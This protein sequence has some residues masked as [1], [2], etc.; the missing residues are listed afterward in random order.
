MDLAS[1]AVVDVVRNFN[2]FYMKQIGLLREGLLDTPFSLTQARIIYELGQQPGISAKQLGQRLGLDAGY[3]SRQVAK[4][5]ESGLVSR[6]TSGQ[7]GRV[8]QLSLTRKG[9]AAFTTLNQRSTSEVAEQLE[10]LTPLDQKKLAECMQSI[11]ALLERR[12]AGPSVTIRAPLAGDMGWVVERQGKVYAQEYNWDWTYEALVAE[13]VAK[14]IRD[15]DPVCERCWIADAGSER[16]GCV[17]LVKDSRTVA[18]LRLLFV[19][20]QARGLG[21]GSRLVDECIAFARAAGYRKIK[22]W[23]NDILH[24]AR[25]IYQ[26]AGFSLVE[27]KPHHSFGHDLNGQTWELSLV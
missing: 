1:G 11:Q 5:E 8:Q 21:V 22:L 3:L 6:K 10:T 19:E 23:T 4:F 18:R 26:R 14:F 7:D 24:G 20:P 12:E 25:R 9:R 2:R 17:F 15:L 16:V 27:E 13:I